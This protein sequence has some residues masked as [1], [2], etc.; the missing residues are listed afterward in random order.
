MKK[1]TRFHALKILDWCKLKYGRGSSPYPTIQ[2]RMPDY[3][4]NQYACGEY[5][6]EDGFIYVNS[7]SHKTLEDLAD[8]I[9]HE[10]AHYRYQSQRDYVRMDT[11]CGYVANPLE[12]QANKLAKRDKKKCVQELKKYYKQFNQ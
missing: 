4:N 1:I 11:Y 2:Y 3:L 6:Y 7:Y 12:K 10:Y 8:T 9:I 5:D